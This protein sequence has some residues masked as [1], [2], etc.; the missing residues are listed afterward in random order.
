MGVVSAVGTVNGVEN[1]NF[2]LIV[3]DNTGPHST[4]GD[5]FVLLVSN[6]YSIDTFFDGGRVRLSGGEETFLPV[7]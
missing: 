6:G 7:M 3:N 1:V 5:E 4:R 2:V